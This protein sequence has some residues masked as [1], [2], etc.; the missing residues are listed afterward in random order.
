MEAA[1]LPMANKPGSASV[2]IQGR[3]QLAIPSFFGKGR[4]GPSDGYRF[5]S[6]RP[7][8]YGLPFDPEG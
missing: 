4:K 8:G 3:V 2:D 5:R 7:A 1:S 6:T